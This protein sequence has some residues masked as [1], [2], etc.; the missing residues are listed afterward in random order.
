MTLKNR[1]II[2]A[3]RTLKKKQNGGDSLVD[4]AKALG[5]DFMENIYAPAEKKGA[6]IREKSAAAIINVA[7]ATRDVGASAVNTVANNI[8]GFTDVLPS[9]DTALGYV[10]APITYPLAAAAGFATA[11]IRM[12]AKTGFDITKSAVLSNPLSYGIRN[13]VAPALEDEYNRPG[14]T[15]GYDTLLKVKSTF[16]FGDDSEDTKELRKSSDY[17]KMTKGVHDSIGNAMKKTKL[18][19]R[20]K[21]LEGDELKKAVER[22]NSV[23]NWNEYTYD[24]PTGKKTFQQMVDQTWKE[25][26]TKMV[27]ALMNNLAFLINKTDIKENDR[28]GIFDGTK[29]KD[30]KDSMQLI[31][32]MTLIWR[33]TLGKSLHALMKNTIDT[34]PENSFGSYS[35]LIRDLTLP[36]SIIPQSTRVEQNAFCNRVVQNQNPCPSPPPNVDMVFCN[37]MFDDKDIYIYFLHTN[38]IY[39]LS[40]ISGKEVAITQT[41][42]VYGMPVNALQF[43][44]TRKSFK[45]AA[46]PYDFY[47][48]PYMKE[49]G[50]IS[51]YV[52]ADRSKFNVATSEGIFPDV[53]FQSDRP[54]LPN[55]TLRKVPCAKKKLI[56]KM[57]NEGQHVSLPCNTWFSP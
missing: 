32:Q 31:K 56:Q 34:M 7:S 54:D 43:R 35:K 22:M 33:A 3:R 57:S 39:N 37:K 45:N 21:T 18:F 41:L 17:L 27:F 20:G 38:S 30:G 51:E 25:N 1:V 24:L 12:A 13:Y 29:D 53:K 9:R 10:T 15:H 2:R 6:E 49:D 40:L 8:K 23:R 28:L 55:F 46:K 47:Y 4:G 11:N 26:R 16:G 48:P 14:N 5:N 44:K 42:E 19:A 52:K 50:T 36:H